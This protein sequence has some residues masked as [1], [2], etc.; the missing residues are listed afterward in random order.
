M[1]FL[2]L[3]GAL[4]SSPNEQFQLAL[5]DLRSLP[6]EKQCVTRYAS[7]HGV[8][9][10]ELNEFL[11]ATTFVVNSDSMRQPV[12]LTIINLSVIRVE[13]DKLGWDQAS[14]SE[15]IALLAKEGVNL[16]IPNPVSN[17]LYIDIWEDMQRFDPYFKPDWIDPA[18][19]IEACR[20]SKSKMFIMSAWFLF[21][22]LMLE[23]QDGGFYSQLLLL[24][25]TV[26]Q[27][28]KRMGVSQAFIDRQ[29]LR[30]GG[31]VIDSE[32][33]LHN[34][35]LREI[36]G[37]F[38]EERFIWDTKDFA[39]DAE[40][41]AK[42]VLLSLAGTAK[43]DGSEYIG[44][45]P[46]NL[47]WYY[48]ANGKGVQLNAVPSNVAIDMRPGSRNEPIHDRNV[49]A[50]YKCLACHGPYSGL[51]PFEDRV[52]I[53][54]INPDAKLKT[55]SYYK[56]AVITRKRELEEFYLPELQ[57]SLQRQQRSY[58][59]AVFRITGLS[60]TENARIVTTIFDRYF[61]ELVGQDRA[62]LEF[63][64][65]LEQAI[66]MWN[67]SGDENLVLL[68]AG[69]PIRRKVWETVV[70]YAYPRAILVRKQ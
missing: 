58:S 14:R 45:L 38:G 46:N 53:G 4:S 70:G 64:Y 61:W 22:R 54:L 56:N 25:P 68:A 11:K 67:E 27:L 47:H 55:Y 41:R 13:T 17:A 66:K 31:A 33:A 62:A 8:P 57:Q 1:L 18:L 59:N 39:V 43:E 15:D 26:D 34:R 28:F 49:V 30:R 69:Q 36:P 24:P 63:G 10:K 21:P 37:T 60:S 23:R 48:I 9:Q 52:K 35:E 5:S 50:W 6:V 51:R 42:N 19:Y 20:L 3:F 7:V 29:R 40:N 44:S 65:P 12:T 16:T 32:V 2:L